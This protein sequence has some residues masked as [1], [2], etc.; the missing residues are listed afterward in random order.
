M[1]ERVTIK[2]VAR[3]SGVSI[4][5]VSNVLN[6]TGSMRPETRQRVQL[7]IRQLGY[8]LNT[9]AR[10]LKTGETRLIGLGIFDFSQPFAPYLTD[11][12]IDAARS[13]GYG[14][15]TCTYGND[16]QGLS[17]I[18]DE[19]YRLGADGWLFFAVQPLEEDATILDQS[20]PVVLMGEYSSYGKTDWVTMSNEQAL[21]ELTTNLIKSGFE[22]IALIGAP[23]DM[24][25]LDRI[26]SSSEGMSELRMRGYLRALNNSGIPVDWNLVV[27]CD[28]I[29][30]EGGAIAASWLMRG[31][32]LPDAIIC[33]TDAAALGAMAELQR[34]GISIP[35]DIQIVG[36]DNVPEGEYATPSLTSVDP[37]VGEY[38]AKAVQMLIERIEGYSG[39]ARTFTTDFTLIERDSTIFSEKHCC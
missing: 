6:H 28:L 10:S 2:D 9:S 18:I 27:P 34:N 1:A 4:K 15:I 23:M 11:K 13:Q 32:T 8:R 39:S 38:A 24:R 20:Y 5:T 3:V 37:M 21:Y 30:R 29:N 22:R 17:S 16:Q 35:R 26:M 33:L 25:N 12:V 14:V 19:T 31:A 7:A 36:F